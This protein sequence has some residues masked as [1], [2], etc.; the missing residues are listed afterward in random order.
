MTVAH[1]NSELTRFISARGTVR[2]RELMAAGFHSEQLSRLV[3]G[4][5][6]VRIGRG[7]YRINSVP[8]A[9]GVGLAE[10]CARVPS[11][12]VCLISA[13]HYHGLGTQLPREVWLAL[14]PGKW[15]STALGWP[16]RFVRM[17][18]PSFNSGVEKMT[19]AE[20]SIRVYGIAKT[21][22]D[23]FK[24]RNRVGLDVAVEALRDAVKGGKVD[25]EALWRYAKVCRITKVIQPYLEA[26]DG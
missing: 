23:C 18:G 21:L 8:D 16:V 14:P 25:Y 10:V 12:V 7:L 19:T 6:V 4:G 17:S 1:R 13:L 24:F 26:L 5:E 15:A 2:A 22:A 20:G 9:S 11:G 3:R